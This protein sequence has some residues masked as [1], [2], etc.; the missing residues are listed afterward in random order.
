MGLVLV[1][2]VLRSSK[3][4]GPRSSGEPI[5]C[6]LKSASVSE[7]AGCHA[8][9]APRWRRQPSGVHI[10]LDTRLTPDLG[11]CGK[12]EGLD[13]DSQMPPWMIDVLHLLTLTAPVLCTSL[14]TIAY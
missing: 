1:V 10:L 7:K 2:K 6:P 4:L 5:T 12:R 13:F 8:S 14:L 11:I 9:G 3:F